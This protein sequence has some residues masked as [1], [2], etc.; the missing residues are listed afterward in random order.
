MQIYFGHQKRFLKN[1]KH[2]TMC[3]PLKS[4]YIPEKEQEEVD[5]YLFLPLFR[6][7]VIN[8]S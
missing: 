6:N 4:T 2:V 1:Q 5:T 8:H 3:I 7:S